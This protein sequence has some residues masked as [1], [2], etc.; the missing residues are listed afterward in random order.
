MSPSLALNEGFPQ[1]SGRVGRWWQL[2]LTLNTNYPAFSN[3]WDLCRA[4][5]EAAVP[6]SSEGEFPGSCHIGFIQFHEF[7]EE[8]RAD[9]LQDTK[10]FVL[11]DN[12]RPLQGLLVYQR[13]SG[14]EES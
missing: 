1:A 8:S 13:R 4:E 3:F 7:M 9:S 10:P 6:H 11:H 12:R 2:F 5:R 14:E